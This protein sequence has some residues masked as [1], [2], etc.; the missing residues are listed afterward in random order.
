MKGVV[1]M[2]NLELEKRV[3]DLETRI[4]SITLALETQSKINHLLSDNMNDLMDKMLDISKTTTLNS[5]EIV[6][7]STKIE[8]EP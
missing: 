1:S 7:L 2:T 4:L 3:A 6:A 8:K 5:M